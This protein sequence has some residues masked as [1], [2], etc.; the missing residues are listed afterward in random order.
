MTIDFDRA[1][2]KLG[3]AEIKLTPT[4]FRLLASLARAAGRVVSARQLLADAQSVVLPESE[5]REI[6][7]VHVR[8]LRAKL[9]PHQGDN[10][11]VVSV[12]GFGYL[13]ERRNQPRAGD[14]LME[15]AETDEV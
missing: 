10:P 15:Y 9:E 13:L 11:Y 1:E 14:F 7:K 12:R 8:R 2:V 4:E 5:A 6:V 3:E